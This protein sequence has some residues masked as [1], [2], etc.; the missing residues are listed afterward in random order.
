[1]NIRYL[2]SILLHIYDLPDENIGRQSIGSQCSP[3][4]QKM[5]T[6]G[7]KSLFVSHNPQQQIMKKE[8]I[9]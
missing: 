9:L 6:L 1:M 4:S 2:Q 3:D 5:Q 8:E 7:E